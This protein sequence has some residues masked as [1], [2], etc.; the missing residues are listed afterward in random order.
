M[1]GAEGLCA[2][3]V[4]PLSIYRSS[5]VWHASHAVVLSGFSSVQVLEIGGRR[6]SAAGE[7]RCAA[8]EF[9]H[10]LSFFRVWVVL[11]PRMGFQFLCC[12]FIVLNVHSVCIAVL[13]FY[14]ICC[15]TKYAYSSPRTLGGCAIRPLGG[16]SYRRTRMTNRPVTLPS[17][18][19]GICLLQQDV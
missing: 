3:E 1:D 12:L 17:V 19:R 14:G 8:C 15:I 4:R 18:P 5:H 16:C 9:T 11:L 2:S 7:D 13:R 6:T 10:A